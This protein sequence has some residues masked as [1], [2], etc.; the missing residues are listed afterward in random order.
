MSWHNSSFHFILNRSLREHDF[1]QQM[2]PD[3]SFRFNSLSQPILSQVEQQKI[4]RK[5]FLKITKLL[6]STFYNCCK[7]ELL[8]IF[9]RTIKKTENEHPQKQV[10]IKKMMLPVILWKKNLI[11]HKITVDTI[12]S[13]H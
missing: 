9:G 1:K 6:F 10:S 12:L 8:L 4:M 3:F 11:C 13:L 2:I 7:S 5:D